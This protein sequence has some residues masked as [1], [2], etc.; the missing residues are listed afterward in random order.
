MARLNLCALL[1]FMAESSFTNTSA[2]SVLFPF[3]V[4][5]FQFSLF[6][7]V[8][9]FLQFGLCLP[10]IICHINSVGSIVRSISR[11]SFDG[12]LWMT[13]LLL[14]YLDWQLRR[15]GIMDIFNKIKRIHSVPACF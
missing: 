2:V 13:L 14:Y 10:E 6:S 11:L 7:A 15:E 12:F 8:L 1:V 5:F 3:S 9:S 4:F